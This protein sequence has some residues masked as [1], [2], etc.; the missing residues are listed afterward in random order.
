MSF[1]SVVPLHYPCLES[2]SS[3]EI[4]KYFRNMLNQDENSLRFYIDIKDYISAWNLPH[5]SK[6]KAMVKQ[7]VLNELIATHI[8]CDDD[9]LIS[10]FEQVG[11][12]G[13]M[14]K[15]WLNPKA[16]PYLINAHL[17]KSGFMSP[18]AIEL[19][20]PFRSVYTAKIFERLIRFSDTGT[21][22]FTP[23]G[24][25]EFT[26]S[27][28]RSYGVIKRDIL[29]KA[30]KE[31]LKYKLLEKKFDITE[32]KSGNKVKRVRISFSLTK[33]ARPNKAFTLDGANDLVRD[34][35]AS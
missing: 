24:I 10:V 6:A 25:C 26:N 32:I 19:L 1:L 17:T 30:E 8:R 31:L 21:L 33:K 34:V 16:M 28:S 2:E 23:E 27:K 14:I 7:H 3:K 35:Y 9:T 29:L 12:G 15:V 4:V 13:T 20:Q 11:G 18:I 22:I 5:P